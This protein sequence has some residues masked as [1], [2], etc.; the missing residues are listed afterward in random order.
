MISTKVIRA[1][2]WLMNNLR[3]IKPSSNPPATAR[4]TDKSAISSRQS[5]S[6]V[7]GL[8]PPSQTICANGDRQECLSYTAHC[9]LLTAHCSLLCDDVADAAIVQQL[10]EGVEIFAQNFIK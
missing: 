5:Q 3:R 9:L 1:S 4:G 10:V 8:Y 2:L 6:A 7:S